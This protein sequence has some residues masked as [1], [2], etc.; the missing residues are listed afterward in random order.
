MTLL[1]FSLQILLSYCKFIIPRPLKWVIHTHIIHTYSYLKI[2]IKILENSLKELK[3][4]YLVPKLEHGFLRSLWLE[5]WPYTKFEII[6]WIQ[7]HQLHLQWKFKLLAGKFT[8]GNKANI[9]GWCQQTFCFQKF[10]DNAQQC[11]AFTPQTN[12]PARNLNFCWRWRWWDH[13]Q[14][15]FW[16][17]FYSISCFVFLGYGNIAPVTTAGRVFCLLFA[18]VGI[19]FTLSVIAD[20][21]QI[22]ATLLLIT[23][24]RNQI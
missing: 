18:I 4:N 17:I 6:A 19:P 5:L 20:V 7:S 13:I 3:E 22:F 8:W 10:V 24:T 16:N 23:L 9:A 1:W 21:G 15:T 11:F 2:F 14:A 12:F